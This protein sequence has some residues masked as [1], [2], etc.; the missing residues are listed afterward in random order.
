M[1][2]YK[3]RDILEYTI[4]LVSEFAV[5]F[6]MTDVQAFRYINQFNGIEVIENNYDMM[7]TLSFEDVIET[8]QNYCRRKGG[9]L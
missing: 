1:M 6:G 8:I 3:M 7:H 5:K 4:A 2:K 9:S